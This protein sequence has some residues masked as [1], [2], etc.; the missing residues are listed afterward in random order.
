MADSGD[1]DR[2]VVVRKLIDDPVR[3]DSQRVQAAKPATQRIAGV[4]LALEQR[5]GFLGG[6]DQRPVERKQLGARASREYQSSHR[7]LRRS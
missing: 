4:R 3:A 1:S 5:E 6:V 7:L 2:L